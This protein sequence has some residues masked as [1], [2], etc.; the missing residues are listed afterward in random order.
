MLSRLLASFNYESP[1]TSTWA[2]FSETFSSTQ[3]IQAMGACAAL[4]LA[5]GANELLSQWVLNNFS[6]S[7]PWDWKREIVMITGGC[8]GIGEL[9][10]RKLAS[11][12]IKVVVVDLHPSKDPLPENVFY[13]RLDVTSPEEI[14]RVAQSIRREVGEP[15][16]L[17]NNA[18]VASLKTILDETEEE[19]RRTFDVNVVAHF[20]LIREFLPHMISQNH[21]HI[22][23]VASMASFV[24]VA[25]GVDYSCSKAAA[26][27]FHEGLMQELKYKYKARNIRARS[28]K[29]T[30]S[31]YYQ[32]YVLTCGRSVVHP[33]WIRT[34]MFDAALRKGVFKD[35]LLLPN[36][37]ADSVV[38]LVLNGKSKQIFLPWYFGLGTILRALPTWFQEYARG[39]RSELLGP[40]LS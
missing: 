14:R 25:S 7:R 19:I 27:A 11:R 29:Q 23:T 37:V 22:V 39:S 28:V 3:A 18:G 4:A 8:D 20:F 38:R 9:I 35:K 10:A 33:M 1:D 30:M 31:F 36:D 26:L 24:T 17:I 16:I 21:G 5:F 2:H 6:S 34:S 12:G 32:A 40:N 15:T 13:Y